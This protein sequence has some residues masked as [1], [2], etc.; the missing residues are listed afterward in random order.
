MIWSNL[1]LNCWACMM[2]IEQ[3][4]R[5]RPPRTLL[6][7]EQ[8]GRH[9]QERPLLQ[10][11][12]PGKQEW[13]T[14]LGTSA[15]TSQHFPQTLKALPAPSDTESWCSSPLI[16]H[17][18]MNKCF[19]ILQC[20]LWSSSSVTMRLIAEE[21]SVLQDTQLQRQPR[22]QIYND[23]S[24]DERPRV[25]WVLH[26]CLL[27]MM[28]NLFREESWEASFCRSSLQHLYLE[29]R[30]YKHRWSVRSSHPS[31]RHSMCSGPREF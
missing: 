26:A 5:H 22:R 2:H 15:K 8:V 30:L 27:L 16:L 17:R 4:N 20:K 28:N 1:N 19:P 21:G 23:T 11:Q 14:A 9:R 12:Q 31:A 29:T 6:Q 24:G 3:H 13:G 10:A 18:G 25:S 7:T